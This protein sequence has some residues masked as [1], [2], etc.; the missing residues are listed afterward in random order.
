MADPAQIA[1]LLRRTEYVAR[2]DRVTALSLGTLRVLEQM[3]R[4]L[5]W[6]SHFLCAVPETI[7]NSVHNGKLFANCHEKLLEML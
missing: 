3:L 7:Y 6:S 1:H 5:I 2:P 4:F